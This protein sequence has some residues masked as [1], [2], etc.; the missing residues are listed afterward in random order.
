MSE[1]LNSGPG[2]PAPPSSAPIRVPR[3][4][5]ARVCP[6]DPDGQWVDVL[7]LPDG[8]TGVLLGCC[9]EPRIAERVRRDARDTLQ[10]NG[11]PVASISR[12]NGLPVSAVCAVIGPTSIRY[13][14]CG[15]A[16][17]LTEHGPFTESPVADC[18]G[19]APAQADLAHAD[20]APGMTVLLS[21]VPLQDAT[22][23]LADGAAQ[24][25]DQLVD[26]L[27]AGQ[28]RR[29]RLATVVYRHPPAPLTITLPAEPASLADIRS[30]LRQWLSRA[31]LDPETCADVLLAIG[32]ATA[33]S[34]EHAIVGTSRPVS[35]TVSVALLGSRLLM[36]VSDNGQWKPASVE[37]GYRGHGMHLI[38]ALADS[39]ELT[40]TS[41]GTTVEML[42]EL[43]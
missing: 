2:V 26:R 1:A 30:H 16:A 22:A 32:E 34:S 20:L 4:F 6:A 10:H 19:A 41:E 31:G 40:A 3:G 15:D 7:P 12:M 25:P 37:Q 38:N 17:V 13:S 24:H 35:L 39:V 9:V 8:R 27:I 11:D 28:T 43:P 14:T 21:T 18:P 33:N 36:R 5:A 23:L 42:K 29:E